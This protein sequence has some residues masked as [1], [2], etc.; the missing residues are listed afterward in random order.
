MTE[1][2]TL[3]LQKLLTLVIDAVEIFTHSYSLNVCMYNSILGCV[4]AN[5]AMG[6]LRLL[7]DTYLAQRK[8]K[9]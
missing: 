6:W 5:K 9:Y 2:S 8:N 3:K 1:N 7:I 4:G